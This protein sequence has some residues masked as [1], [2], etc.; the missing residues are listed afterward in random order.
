ML[1]L[2]TAAR[3]DTT[4]ASAKKHAHTAA[5]HTTK[6]PAEKHARTTRPEHGASHTASSH[7]SSSHATSSHTTSARRH[8]R[9]RTA[10]RHVRTRRRPRS[11]RSIARSRR[12]ERAF[13]AST[14]LRPM[15]QQLAKNRSAAAYAGVTAYAR[16]HSGEAA[17]A[18]YLA[19]GNAY[20]LDHRYPEAQE[21]LA[22]ARKAG[23]TLADYADYLAAQADIG[24]G[25]PADAEKL[26]TGFAAKYPSSIFVGGLPVT[27]ANLATSQGDPQRALTILRAH[28]SDPIAGHADYQL[29]LAKATQAAGQ[30][31]EAARLY[32]HI[33]L[34]FPLHTE[35]QQ[36][37]E[38]LALI[39][40][41]APMT[42]EE[43]RAHADALYA[44]GRY[45]DAA[46]EYRA[47]ATDTP[48]GQPAA[49][50]QL[51]VA[52]AACE[53]K[54]KRLSRAQAEALPDLQD[55]SGARRLYLL[56]ELAR[57][58]DD[59][60]QQ[61][62]IVAHMEQRF[63]DSRWLAEALYS[64]GNM[65]LLK[66]DYAQAVTYYLEL[67]QRFPRDRYARR[68]HWRAAW[69]S[70]RMGRYSDAAQL[71]DRQIADYPGGAEIAAALYWR[72][73]LYEQQEHSP[74][75]A[76]AYYSAVADSFEHYYY[77]DMAR[78]Q[79]TGLGDVEPVHVAAL[80]RIH[81]EEIPPLTDDVP[82]DDEHVIKARLLA[83]AGLNEY[84]SPEIQAAD[85]SRQWGAFAEAE[86]YSSDGETFRAMEVLKRALPFYPSAPIDALPMSY[87]KI[88]FPQPYWAA[89][90]KDSAKNGLDPYMVASL[91]R[92]ESE[93]NASA[94]SYANAWGLMQLLPSVGKAMA[95]QE[96][97]RHFKE[98]D[99]L[100][101]ETNIRLGTRYLKQL[102]SE[103]NGQ[104]EF[105]FAAY[106]A[107]DFRVTDWRSA[108]SYTGIDEFVESIPFTETRNYVEAI[109]RNE[110]MYRELDQAAGGAGDRKGTPA[111]N[112]TSNG[113][114]DHTADRA[115]DSSA[116]SS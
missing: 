98:T 56:M 49:R 25:K 67:A 60:D 34:G 89:I 14:Q 64:S 68:C 5:H 4:T 111:E 84:I 114:G 59:G 83:N 102:M 20:L 77:A 63:P 65:Y 54:L 90:K 22:K 37:K 30:T 41:L 113:A 51:L 36:A 57:N 82:E 12:L 115:V 95:R 93:F 13:V 105:A 81:R 92:Q 106:N 3:A 53:L 100:D 32:R 112:R 94:I 35:G 16:T 97:I 91:I 62:S 80:A 23:D 26:L 72:G 70:Y 38:Q 18:A 99:L 61:K 8:G 17:S 47:L 24:A 48:A 46:E 1:P 71:M 33:F 107:G 39:G 50:A 103:F 116:G 88:L 74:A 75:T 110:E 6:H 9:R 55:E 87:W 66:K 78:A 27:L 104:P 109:L 29:A 69:L 43:R 40:A 79:L 108:G 15:A 101:P 73:R 85:G 52:E 76:A 31:A 58:R 21:N 7:K 45:A 96:G 2:G 86:I 42:V 44:G 10:A 28:A 11:A 19:L